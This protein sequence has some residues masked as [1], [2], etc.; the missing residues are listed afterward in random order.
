M[1]YP[2]FC[3]WV[4]TVVMDIVDSDV[5]MPSKVALRLHAYSVLLFTSVL[6]R[7]FL[8]VQVGLLTDAL[9]QRIIEYRLNINRI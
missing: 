9:E 6:Y 1:G 3:Y 4:P 8:Y 2:T 7:T 5:E